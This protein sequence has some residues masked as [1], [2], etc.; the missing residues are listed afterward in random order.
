MEQRVGKAVCALAVLVHGSWLPTLVHAQNTVAFNINAQGVTK[1]VAEWGVDTAW[2]SFDNVR[3][4]I[5]HIGAN[6]VDLFRLTFHPA[7][8]LSDNGDGT[9]SLSST[10][11]GFIDNQLALAALG[12]NKQLA[13]M[14]GEF[15]PTYDHL[16]WLRTIKATQEYINSR[17]GWTTAPIKSIEVYNEPD[18][19]VGQGSAGQLNDLITQLKAYPEFQNTAFPAGSTLNSNNSWAWYDSVPAATEG[20]SHLLGGSLTSWVNFIEHVKST[21]KPFVNPELHSLGEA[22]VGAEHGMASGIFWG[23]ALRARGLFAQASDGKRLGYFEDLSRQSAAAV[24]RAPDGNVYAFAGGLERFGTPTAYRFVSTDAD[25]YFNGIPVREFM[26][27][28]KADEIDAVNPPGN[29]FENYGSWSNQ[30]AYADIDTEPG[31]PALDG[32][33]WKIVNRQTGLVLEVANGSLGDGP[34]IRGAVDDDALQQK[35]NI[36]RTRNGYYHLYN[37]NS[38]R[39]AEVAGGSLDNGAGL[40]QWGTADNQNQQ[41]YIEETGDGYFFIRNAYSNKYMTSSRANV[42]QWDP[43][44]S[45]SQHWQFVLANPDPS[46]GFVAHYK[47]DGSAADSVGFNH[48]TVSGNP[49]YLGGKY[50]QGINLD[51]VDDFVTLPSGVANSNDI[52]IAAWVKWDGGDAWQRIFDFGD[53]TSSYMFLTPRSAANT[54]RFAITT[55]GSNA[56]QM[57]ETAA[58]PTG[59]WVHLAITLGGNTGIL[60]VNGEPRVAGQILL[61]PSDISPLNNYIG[62]SQWPDPLLNGMID[63][64]RIYDFA[65]DM[66]QVAGLVNSGADFDHDGDVDA[67]DLVIWQEAYGSNSLGDADG[68]GDSDGR[69]FL[70]W[71]RSFGAGAGASASLSVPEP[72]A[73]MQVASLLLA[74]GWGKRRLRND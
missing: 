68:D 45:Q 24:Y 44:G 74:L 15:G 6:N 52:T 8:P 28:T 53:D 33:R 2:P 32:Y 14:P 66:S 30:G 62:K 35:W 57:L 3:Q 70:V 9:Y 11:K 51:G 41:W 71:Q 50:G 26:L 5:A 61:D 59:E 43:L 37:A 17:P 34:A 10:A 67:D 18:F 31:I 73:I 65:L 47:L 16:H 19:W 1:S 69:D 12:G 64:L 4:S 29:D 56:E 60:Y 42:S 72:Q 48:A 46:E 54:M 13:L 22:I 36:E 20:S 39:T 21:G 63:D 55:G 58:L 25:V 49:S 40:R 7:Y 27:H 23:D 38:N